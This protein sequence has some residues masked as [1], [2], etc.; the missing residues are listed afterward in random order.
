MIL[1]GK[2]LCKPLVAVSSAFEPCWSVFVG[3]LSA[4]GCGNLALEDEN[5]VIF[6]DG[7]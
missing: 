4:V 1:P 6:R 5:V 2:A 7:H 3:S